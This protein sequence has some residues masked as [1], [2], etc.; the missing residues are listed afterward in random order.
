MFVGRIVTPKEDI[1]AA[2]RLTL[3]ISQEDL[4]R[5]DTNEMVSRASRVG[6][7]AY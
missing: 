6:P 3:S 1:A 4:Q 2:V 5:Q 7:Q